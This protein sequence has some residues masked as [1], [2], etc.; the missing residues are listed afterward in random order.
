MKAGRTY[1][2]CQFLGWG[3]YSAVGVV[4][5][6]QDIGWRATIFVSWGAFLLY[7]VA[8]THR[9]RAAIRRRQWAAAI[10]RRTA[11]RLLLGAMLVAAIQT[12]LVLSIDFL[13]AS[14]KGNF[15]HFRTPCGCG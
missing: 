6:G 1:W 14:G 12:V 3:I 8:L 9:F 7:S 13:L 15:A 4:F 11:P 2:L 10:T 5:T